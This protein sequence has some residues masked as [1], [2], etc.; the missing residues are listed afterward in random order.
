MMIPAL[1][2]G[3]ATRAARGRD[4]GDTPLRDSKEDDTCVDERHQSGSGRDH[5]NETARITVPASVDRND[6]RRSTAA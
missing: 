6:V 5:V 3:G 2:S 1:M 4:E